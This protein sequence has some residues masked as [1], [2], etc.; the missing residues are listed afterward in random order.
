MAKFNHVYST[1]QYIYVSNLFYNCNFVLKEKLV[2]L[3]FLL[4][5]N[6]TP[7]TTNKEVVISLMKKKHIFLSSINHTVDETLVMSKISE[8]L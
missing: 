8:K 1:V 3:V 7:I 6:R 5:L 4:L 2:S